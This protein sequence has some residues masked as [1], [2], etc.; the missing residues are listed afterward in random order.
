MS[1]IDWQKIL[2]FTEEDIQT[3][4]CIGYS[5]MKQG[6][7]QTAKLIFESLLIISN[8]QEYDLQILGAI[9][10]ELNNNKEALQY[11]E[12]ALKKNPDHAPTLLNRTKALLLSG[13]KSSGIQ[14]ARRLEKNSNPIISSQASALLLAY[15]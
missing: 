3:L 4:R 6:H 8:E 9:H 10:L 7:Y 11:L 12:Q 2:D 15:K 1:A 5:Y 13:Y 14:L